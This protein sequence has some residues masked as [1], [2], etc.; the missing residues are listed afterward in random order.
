MDNFPFLGQ[1]RRKKSGGF[2]LSTKTSVFVDK[3]VEKRK[4]AT[5]I[6]RFHTAFLRRKSS[7]RLAK[8]T[9]LKSENLGG[10]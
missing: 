5:K 4:T 1:K 9:F 6:A 7:F 10:K 8:S 2:A 3:A